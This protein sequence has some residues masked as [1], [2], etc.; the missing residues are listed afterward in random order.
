MRLD[1]VTELAMQLSAVDRGKLVE[2]LLRSLG[3]DDDVADD[4]PDDDHEEAWTA[5]IELR[6]AEVREGKVALVDADEV[7]RQAREIITRRR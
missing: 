6:V 2:T 3:P 4:L 5:E 1:A 7:F